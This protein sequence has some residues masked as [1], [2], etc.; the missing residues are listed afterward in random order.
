MRNL[1]YEVRCR[2]EDSSECLVKSQVLYHRNSRKILQ[3]VHV[4][5]EAHTPIVRGLD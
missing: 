4:I 1:V 3:I 5:H 2:Y